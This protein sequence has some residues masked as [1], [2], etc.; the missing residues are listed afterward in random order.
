[1]A[2]A[3]IIGVNNR[4]LKDF[5]V[6]TAN[7]KRLRQM[8]PGDIIFVSESGIS[9]NEDIK[10]LRDA[11]VDAVLIGETLMKADD[12]TAKLKELRRI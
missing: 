9:S 11:K 4:N 3:R 1:K 8:I 7:S 6:D 2:G 12:K 5:S 10:E